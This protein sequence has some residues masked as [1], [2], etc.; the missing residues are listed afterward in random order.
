MPMGCQRVLRASY[1]GL[2]TFRG[3]AIGCWHRGQRRLGLHKQI[4]CF[5]YADPRM[6][7][8]VSQSVVAPLWW[9]EDAKLCVPLVNIIEVD[10]YLA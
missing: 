10:L 9:V 6:M 2:S 8:R 3:R 4:I 1:V 5:G 7:H